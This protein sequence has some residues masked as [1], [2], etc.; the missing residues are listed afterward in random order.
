MP[1]GKKGPAEIFLQDLSRQ[2]AGTLDPAVI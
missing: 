2:Q 1:A